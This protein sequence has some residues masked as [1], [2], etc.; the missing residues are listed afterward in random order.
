[1]TKKELEH[2]LDN[3]IPITVAD[4]ISAGD[5]VVSLISELGSR[6][7]LKLIVQSHELKIVQQEAAIAEL[8][9]KLSALTDRIE[10]FIFNNN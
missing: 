6:K 7:R 10:T 5:I 2:K 8:E 3:G 1:M 9:N 4:I